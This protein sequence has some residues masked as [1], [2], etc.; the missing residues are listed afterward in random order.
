MIDVWAGGDQSNQADMLCISSCN[1]PFPC[2]QCKEKKENMCR[3]GNAEPRTLEEIDLLSHTVCGVCP[4]CK[5]EIVATKEEVL[6]PAKQMVKAAAGDEE[7]KSGPVFVWLKKQKLSWLYAHFGIKYGHH[8]LIRVRVKKWVLCILHM[9]L[10]VKG[11]LINKTLFSYLGEYGNADEQKTKVEAILTRNGVWIRDGAVKAKSKDMNAAY[12]KD[13]SF[14]G[15]DAVAIADLAEEMLDVMFPPDMRAEDEDVAEEHARAL[16][17]W[18]TYRPLWRLLNND[19]VD[20]RDVQERK[21]R[22]DQV[23]KLADVFLDAWVKAVGYTQGLYLHMLH[24]HVA[25]WVRDLGDLRPYASHGLEHAHSIRKLIARHL[26][27]RH[28]HAKV[29]KDGK[30]G[31]ARTEQCLSTVTARKEMMRQ[32]GHAL[33]QREDAANT[34]ARR[35]TQARRIAKEK[36]KGRVKVVADF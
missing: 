32:G 35:A 12:K 16:L 34:K 25:D 18:T 1:G 3:K 5:V 8:P 2:V 20:V 24:A 27:N 30:M 13:I 36:E 26:T 21:E 33:Q 28:K 17:C 22:G 6:D 9:D 10:R 11:G 14:V 29:R 31:K 7:P 19:F 23:Q 4:G 15:R